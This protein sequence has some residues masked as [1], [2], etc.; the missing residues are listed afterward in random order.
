[1]SSTTASFYDGTRSQKSSVTVSYSQDYFI[2]IKNDDESRRYLLQKIEISPRLGNLPHI[3]TFPDGASCEV[4][5][6]KFMDMLIADQYQPNR[7]NE[8]IHWLESKFHIALFAAIIT[9]AFVWLSITTGLPWLSKQA[10]NAMPISVNSQIGIET[11]ALM[12]KKVFEPSVLDLATQQRLTDKFSQLTDQMEPT[13]KQHLQ[14]KFRNSP[15]VGANAFALPSGDIIITD[16]LIELAENDDEILG[17][18]AHEIGHIN[19]RHSLRQVIQTTGLTMIFGLA[20]GDV[21]SI[22]SFTALLPA[23]LVELKYSREFEL[24]AD[25]YAVQQLQQ[26]G[27]TSQH[28]AKLLERLTQP[29]AHVLHN[30]FLST[31]PLT[32]DRVERMRR[33][34]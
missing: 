10:A 18:L 32:E 20:L 22:T 1:M 4:P 34:F 26:R 11:L 6:H 7:F 30:S 25:D 14:L 2:H 21:T 31:H 33:S 28:Y 27:I 13:I 19:A 9:V 12:D 16:Q 5:D 24:E 17:V 23:I 15:M 3:L 29:K 8:W